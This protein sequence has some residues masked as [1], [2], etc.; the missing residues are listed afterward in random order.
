MEP[1]KLS[2][3]TLVVSLRCSLRCKLCA[4]HAPYYDTPPDYSLDELCKSVDA[5]FKTVDFCEKFTINGGE[6]F[7]YK[8]LPELIDYLQN[9]KNQIGLLEILTNGTI[10]PNEKLL[11]SLKASATMDVMVNDYGEGLSRAKDVCIA[12]ARAGIMY[13]HR[14][15]HDDLVHFGG[16]VDLTD[17]SE[18]NR[19]AEKTAE[20]YSKCAYPGPFNCFVLFGGKGYVCGVQK[21]AEYLGIVHDMPNEYIDFRDENFDIAATREKLKNFKNREF[22]SACRFCNGFCNDSPRFTPAEQLNR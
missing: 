7:M 13:R 8:E 16:W 18:K 4:V 6:P 19:P 2:G 5:Y 22:F 1:F 10:V 14:E 12:L 20:I 17:L 9:Y 15:Q 3:T 21:R 11:R